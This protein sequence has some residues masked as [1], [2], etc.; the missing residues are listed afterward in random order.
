[1]L[2]YIHFLH[3]EICL[4][5]KFLYILLIL[6]Q[7]IKMNEDKFKLRLKEELDKKNVKKCDLLN[8]A[9]LYKIMK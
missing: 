7:G 6:D 2:N 9:E 4:K 3:N 5:I 8:L 1:M